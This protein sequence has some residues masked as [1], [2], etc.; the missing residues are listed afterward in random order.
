MPERLFLVYRRGPR[1]VVSGPY[2]SWDA[3]NAR[4]RTLPQNTSYSVVTA[5]SKANARAKANV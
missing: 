1:L 2:A 4:K 5:D 3:V